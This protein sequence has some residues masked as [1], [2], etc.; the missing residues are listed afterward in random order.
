ME[1]EY[2]TGMRLGKGL[3]HQA[4]ML[5]LGCES[6]RIRLGVLTEITNVTDGRTDRSV[7]ADTALATKIS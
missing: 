2:V 5:A 6:L 4:G 3:Q 7:V 1:R